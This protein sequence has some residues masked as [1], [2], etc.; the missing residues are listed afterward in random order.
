MRLANMLKKWVRIQRAVFAENAEL[1]AQLELLVQRIC[2]FDED[3]RRWGK[4]LRL[5]ISQ[6]RAAASKRKKGNH[7]PHISVHLRPPA[8]SSS[9]SG[10]DS[11][12]ASSTLSESAVLRSHHRHRHR[13]KS[14]T[15]RTTSRL[16]PSKLSPRRLITSSGSADSIVSRNTRRSGAGA[17][18]TTINPAISSTA[19]S[20]SASALF[21]TSKTRSKTRSNS[22]VSAKVHA[23]SHSTSNATANPPVLSRRRRLTRS[24]Q[25]K[26][27]KKAVLS[28]RPI[29][30]VCGV[31]VWVRREC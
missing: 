9:G 15:G 18:T 13:R 4:V 14:L 5:S 12:S 17:I 8:P 22:K 3:S 25:S 11:S 6:T 21:S 31:V 30:Y 16:T 23:T 7:L 27:T 1:S 2:D 26:H 20:S 19:A 24:R 10:S 29:Q 28:D